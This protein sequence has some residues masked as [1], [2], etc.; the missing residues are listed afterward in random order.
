MEIGTLVMHIH[1]HT[2]G[3]GMVIDDEQRDYTEGEEYMMVTVHWLDWMGVGIYWT[4]ELEEVC[5]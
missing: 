5:S 1:D 3:I 2:Q 4:D